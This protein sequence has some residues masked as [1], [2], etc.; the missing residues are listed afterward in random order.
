MHLC[1]QYSKT[2]PLQLIKKIIHTKI[3]CSHCQFIS[4]M[5]LYLNLSFIGSLKHII[6]ILFLLSDQIITLHLHSKSD[7]TNGLY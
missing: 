3:S 6:L 5:L 4:Y 1:I 2:F 7:Y